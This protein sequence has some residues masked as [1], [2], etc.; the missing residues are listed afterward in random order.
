[1]LLND[2]LGRFLEQ[3]PYCVMVRAALE[4][5]LSAKR[6]DELFD[7]KALEQYEKVLLFS[8]L[9]EVI[10]RVVTR[11][12]PSV[13]ASYRALR[14][15]LGVSDEAVYQKLRKVE[16]AVSE[17]LVRDSFAQASGVLVELGVREPS[18]LHKHQVKVLDGNSLSASD[19]RIGELREIWD[20]PLPGRTL[21]VWDQA[22]R[23]IENV[24]LL[25]DGHASERSQLNRVLATVKQNDLW[26]ADRNFCTLGFMFGIAEQRARFVIRQHGQLEGV[27]Q[28][29]RR[30]VGRTKKGEPVFEQALLIRFRGR[31]QKIRRITI[32]LA[33]PTRDGDRELHI[34][35]NLTI[36]QASAVKVGELYARRWTIETVFLELQTA[37]NC[38]VS[39]LGYPRAALFVFCVAL[40][41]QNT[42]SM[43]MGSL[44]A[45]HGRETVDEQVSGV[46]LSQELQKTYD[47]MMVQAP[48]EHWRVF[49]K[50]SVKRFAAEL[51]K[52]AARVDIKRYR[53]TKRGPKKPSPEKKPYC[54]GGHVSTA[55]IL[56]LRGTSQ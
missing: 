6:L 52:L 1:M 23:L 56:A 21:V 12:E 20:A 18:W 19:R 16:T 31:T 49:S 40:L 47:G 26:I 45:V 24:F 15:V 36:K 27:P 2:L 4:R 10:A 33:A 55:K 9:V 35:T 46:L 50:M 8:S 37:L 3:R 34:L 30:R 22:S 5:M 11:V 39:T 43:L 44:R 51:K 54:N 7:R 41:L 32:K 17:E 14:E 53:K 13:L 25:E 38:E 42:I 29:N 28:G 48:P